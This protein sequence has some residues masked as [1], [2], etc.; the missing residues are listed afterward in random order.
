MAK[1]DEN[2]PDPGNNDLD[3]DADG[4]D[5][6]QEPELDLDERISL[7]LRARTG[8]TDHADIRE[9]LTDPEVTRGTEAFAQE[10]VAELDERDRQ[11]AATAEEA[12]RQ[13]LAADREQRKATLKAEREQVAREAAQK[14]HQEDLDAELSAEL[15]SES[16]IPSPTGPSAA[17]VAQKIVDE[18]L[19]VVRDLTRPIEE[20]AEAAERGIRARADLEAVPFVVDRAALDEAAK[21]RLKKIQE[22]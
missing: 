13:R 15:D 22:G 1:P 5:G 7:F 17:D 10:L 3:P 4:G 16:G 12:E 14:A 20:R 8:K 6:D 18:S 9:A 2:A 11:D 19:E 21:A